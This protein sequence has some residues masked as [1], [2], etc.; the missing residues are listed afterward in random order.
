MVITVA[1]EYGNYQLHLQ[2]LSESDRIC[3]DYLRGKDVSFSL[4]RTGTIFNGV[5]TKYSRIDI[6]HIGL[7]LSSLPVHYSRFGDWANPLRHAYD[8]QPHP[9]TV[10]GEP[11]RTVKEKS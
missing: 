9:C 2:S 1:R 7:N 4:S 6:N 3:K 8:R 10:A 11:R 5:R